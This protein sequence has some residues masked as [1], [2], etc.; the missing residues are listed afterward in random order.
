MDEFYLEEWI[1]LG[2]L[3]LPSDGREY[4]SSGLFHGWTRDR[5]T[6][7][8]GPFLLC[9]S[10]PWKGG[11]VKGVPTHPSIHPSIR[12]QGFIDP[13]LLPTT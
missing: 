11:R 13:V 12:V 10:N 6:R 8:V 2:V 7:S 1:I 3:F 9:F 5:P 4:L